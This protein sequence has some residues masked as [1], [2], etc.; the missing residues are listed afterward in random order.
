MFKCPFGGVSIYLNS[1]HKKPRKI[2]VFR[3]FNKFLHK[4]HKLNSKKTSLSLVVASL[5]IIVWRTV[6]HDEQL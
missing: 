5:Q 4:L 6:V 1:R 2:N 3:G